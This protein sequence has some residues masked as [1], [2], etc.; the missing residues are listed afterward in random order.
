MLQVAHWF[1]DRYDNLSSR[2][3]LSGMGLPAIERKMPFHPPGPS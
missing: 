3:K 1:N 2:Q